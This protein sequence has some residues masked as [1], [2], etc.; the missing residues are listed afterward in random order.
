RRCP[1]ARRSNRR[2]GSHGGRPRA[3]SA[4]WPRR[5]T[6]AAPSRSRCPVSRCGCTW[7]RN[8]PASWRSSPTA[9]RS[10]SRSRSRGARRAGRRMDRKGGPARR[11]ARPGPGQVPTAPDA[12]GTVGIALSGEPVRLHLGEEL[13]CE[14]EIE[15]YGDKVEL[16]IEFTWRAPRGEVDERRDAP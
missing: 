6:P 10:S 16:E 3:G 15:P 13:T 5:S 4:R 7:A 8:S 2:S 9:T 14:L 12:G 11:E 1:E